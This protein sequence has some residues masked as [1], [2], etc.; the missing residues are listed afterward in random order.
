MALIAAQMYTLR[1]HCKTPSDIAASCARVKKMG[2]DGVQLSVNGPSEPTE[3]RKIL[4]GEGLLCAATHR[5]L[6]QMETALEALI[7]EHQ[8]IGCKY[9]AIG[10]YSPKDNWTRAG[11]GEFVCRYNAIAA[12]LAGT[13]LRVGYHNHSHELAPAE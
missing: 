10:G 9:T 3:L 1:E 2:Y 13:G 7:E 12:K 5:P 4:D 11:W 8:I 6:D